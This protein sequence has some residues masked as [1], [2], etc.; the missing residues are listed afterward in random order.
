MLDMTNRSKNEAIKTGKALDAYLSFRAHEE[1]VGYEFTP[2]F[3]TAAILDGCI[4][5]FG[6]SFNKGELVEDEAQP[7]LFKK[8]KFR[9]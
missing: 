6:I 9:N 7:E 4:K 2:E 3:F 8:W 1:G 5:F